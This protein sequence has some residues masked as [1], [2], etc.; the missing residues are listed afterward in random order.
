MFAIR[1]ANA[2]SRS[3]R[4]HFMAL[5]PWLAKASR[6]AC[7]LDRNR[8]SV[9]QFTGSAVG[10][11][12]YRSLLVLGRLGPL[13][14]LEV[15]ARYWRLRFVCEKHAIQIVHSH[16]WESDKAFAQIRQT[17]G[18]RLVSSLHGHYELMEEL[19]GGADDQS[20]QQLKTMDAVVYLSRKHK[21]TLDKFGVPPERRH[22]IFYGISSPPGMIATK[23]RK[24][25]PLKLVMA[26]RGIPD[27]GWAETLDAVTAIHR[28]LGDVISI[29][30]LGSGETLDRLRGRYQ[31]CQFVRFLGYCDNILPH[32]ASA[33]IGLLPSYYPAESL[34]NTII[35]YLICG[36]PVIATDVGA[37]RDMVTHNGQVAGIILPLT[38]DKKVSAIDI[39]SAIEAYLHDAG[40]VERDSCV[41]LQAA[42][43]FQMGRCVLSYLKVYERILQ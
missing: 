27:K 3:V 26:A 31:S 5:R 12:I 16:S 42:R 8:V 9:I 19:G 40:R 36:K 11:L 32:V 37:I 21:A 35:E 14:D 20:R 17:A 39:K 22:Q 7:L 24:E 41:A 34:P 13:R 28:E 15:R 6:Q 43:Q 1:L 4:V 38:R 23:H 29:D 30:L 25:E 10:D 2:L 18:I 33:H